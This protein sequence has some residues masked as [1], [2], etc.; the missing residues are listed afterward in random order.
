[1]ANSQKS[2]LT[3][4]TA[5]EMKKLLAAR[6]RL[7]VLLEE[8]GKLTKSLDRIEAELSKLL[9]GAGK[10]TSKSPGRKKPG[11]KKKVGR[12]KVSK[13]TTARKKVSRRKVVKKKVTKKKVAKILV[14]DPIKIQM[15]EFADIYLR[16]AP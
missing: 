13:K 3:I 6:E 8:K 1:M 10:A 4:L 9:D 5:A 16:N 15:A 14:A 12:K 2:F 7:D 11:P